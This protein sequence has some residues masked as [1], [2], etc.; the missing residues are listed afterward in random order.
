MRVLII[1]SILLCSC[2]LGWGQNVLFRSI[3]TYNTHVLNGE[4]REDIQIRT[5]DGQTRALNSLTLDVEYNND[6]EAWA[7]GDTVALNW[8]SEHAGYLRTVSNLSGHYRV[9]VVS[10]WDELEGNAWS[11]TDQ[12]QTLVTLRWTQAQ[13]CDHE[14]TLSPLT[15][16]A[17]FFVS[18]PPPDPPEDIV[19]NWNVNSTSETEHQSVTR[20]KLF[21]QGP[22][23][24]LSGV[25]HTMIKD[26]EMIPLLSPYSQDPRS[27]TSIPDNTV[28]WVLVTLRRNSDGED[29]AYQSAFLRNDGQIINLDGSTSSITL[30]DEPGDY[31]VVVRHRNHLAVM[32]ATVQALTENPPASAYDFTGSSDVYYGGASGASELGESVWGAPAGDADGDNSI[33]SADS[34][35]ILLPRNTE[36]FSGTDVNL[37]GNTTI[38]D[39]NQSKRNE[40]KTSGVQ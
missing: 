31:Y 20:I 30:P 34:T 9:L 33:S 2:G 6:L 29:V 16:A 39:Y 40:N 38:A 3:V 21:L 15:D 14:L 12:W 19:S 11:V 27:V 23:Q 18:D 22:Y 8:F 28:D 5:M 17:A 10:D 36:G 4:Y 32:S 1:M 13:L 26:R 37:D 24:S 7:G 25:M 35:A